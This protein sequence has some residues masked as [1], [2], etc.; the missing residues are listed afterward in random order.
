[1]EQ[2]NEILRRD[3]QPV[4]RALAQTIYEA[5]SNEDERDRAEEHL[6][7]VYQD[8]YLPGLK[9][10]AF[11]AT[12]DFDIPAANLRHG[13]HDAMHRYGRYRARDET[14]QA[15]IDRQ[16][17]RVANLMTGKIL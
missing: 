8:I 13:L 2:V 5:A 12:P 17:D 9:K 1:M 16:I 7:K 11:R 3:V 10:Q 6:L 15:A 14:E 4:I